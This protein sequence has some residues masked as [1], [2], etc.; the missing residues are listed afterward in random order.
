MCGCCQRF[1]S[2]VVCTE[3]VSN[4]YSV[5]LTI[6]NTQ[7]PEAV[8]AGEKIKIIKHMGKTGKTGDEEET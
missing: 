5:F 2:F 7:Q 3:F 8:A 1:K 4:T 6:Q